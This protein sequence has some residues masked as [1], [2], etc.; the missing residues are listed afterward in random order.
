MVRV[1]QSSETH[2]HCQTT[3]SQLY[4]QSHITENMQPPLQQRDPPSHNTWIE[5][6]APGFLCGFSTLAEIMAATG[7]GKHCSPQLIFDSVSLYSG[8]NCCDF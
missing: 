6:A 2:F 8:I 5:R 3:K 4:V 7:L 1:S